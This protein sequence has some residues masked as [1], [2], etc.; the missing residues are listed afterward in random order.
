MKTPQTAVAVAEQKSKLLTII[1]LGL[2]TA[3]VPFSIDMYLPGFTDIA[4]TYNTTT[5]KVALSLSS[6]FIG[7]GIGQLLY[8]PLLDRFGRKRPL[9]AGL[10]LYLLASFACAWAPSIDLL[11]GARFV[12][13]M[14]GCAATIA[15]TAMVR[16]L[17]AAQDSAKVFSYLIL[18]LSVSPLLAPTTGSLLTSTLGWRSIFFALSIVTAL[19]FVLSYF[20]LPQA[21]GPDHRYSLQPRAILKNY[22]AVLRHAYF[23]IYALIGAIAFAGLFVYIASS[24]G[25]FMEQY[26]LTQ[27][28]YGLLFAFLAS[29]LILASQVNTL[30]LKRFSS[31]KIISIS[32]ALQLVIAVLYFGLAKAA[33][34]TMA[35]TIGFLFLF[36]SATGLV[37][38]NA[39]ALAMKPFEE[40]AG[41]A[42]ALL[43]FVQMS[44]GSIATVVI[45]ILNIQSSL[46]MVACMS[47]GSAI[48][49]LLLM[50]SGKRGRAK[51][52]NMWAIN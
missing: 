15:A 19:I 25:I 18:V 13:A 33:A 20:Y 52:L 37:M 39:T 48:A 4:R 22:G 9:F 32:F 3:V 41:S 35:L 7:M 23:N 50:L 51:T 16:D 14:G 40:N 11:I 10:T 36:L 8:G 12:Q 29:G 43:G 49:T 24:P 27:K 34:P 2:L 47:G 26:H 1:I 21:K 31:E 6:F 38:P 17:F 44:L 42:S 28:Q 5:T 46:L 45:G 30:L